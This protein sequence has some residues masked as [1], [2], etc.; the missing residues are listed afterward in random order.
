MSMEVFHASEG[1]LV[2]VYLGLAFALVVDTNTFP[3]FVMLFMLLH[4]EHR[5]LLSPFYSYHK[6]VWS[7]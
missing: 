7:L 3:A 2:P 5:T 4:F 6:I 1:H